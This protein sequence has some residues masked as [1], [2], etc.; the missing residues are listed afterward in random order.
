MCPRTPASQSRQI[1]SRNLPA[2]YY[3]WVATARCVRAVFYRHRLDRYNIICETCYRNFPSTV[4]EH[5]CKR[6]RHYI[7]IG[8]THNPERCILCRI[9]LTTTQVIRD[10]GTCPTDLGY[11]LE[12]LDHENSAAYEDPEP[13][14]LA[15]SE[16]GV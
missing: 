8:A 15:I 9:P 10:C 13:T 12:Y 7:N 2:T 1:V 6:N 5:Y 4:S 16:E 3:D 11:F 14:I